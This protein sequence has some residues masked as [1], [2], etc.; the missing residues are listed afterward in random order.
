MSD[1]KQDYVLATRFRLTVPELAAARAFRTFARER[2]GIDMHVGQLAFAGLVL[3]RDIRHV[4]SAAF[5]TLLLASGNRAGKTALLAV[6]II[7]CCIDKTNRQKPLTEKDALRWMAA[8]YHWYHFGIAQEVADLVF[9]DIVRLLSGTHEGQQGKG[10][11]IAA[12]GPVAQWDTKEYGDY[13][14]V[15]FASGWGGAQVHFRT[16]GEKALGSLGKDMHGVS[17]DEAG[18]ERNLP[19]LIK[20]VFNL[21]RLGTG[22][23]LVMVSTPSEDLGSDFADNWDLGDPTNPRRLPSWRSLRMSSRDNIGYGLDQTMFDRLIADMDQRT[24]AQNIEG[25]FLQ[26]RAAYF[27]G[28]NIED[29]FF[30]GGVEKALSVQNGIYLQ[31]VDPAKSADSAWSITLKI[32]ANPDEPDRPFLVGVNAEQRRGQKSTETLVRLVA[33][34]YNLYGRHGSRCYTAIDA[35]GFGGKMFREAL[36]GIVPDV[37]NVEFGGTI[38]RKRMLLGDLRTLID[39]GRLLLPRAG[40]WL[41]VRKQLLGYRL[42]DR[43]IEQDAVMALCCAVFLLRRTPMGGGTSQPFDMSRAV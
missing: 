40:V 9:S 15:R 7:Y 42:E 36:D 4:Y 39:E 33:D 25:M 11:P 38:Q 27:N 24:I 10:C 14:W 5:L 13:R 41:Q 2:L 3:V 29:V 22:G 43:K 28:A 23:Q 8:E 16:T 30:T 32:V 21:R 12:A 26:A 34:A 19:F 35:T 17:F 1:R 6:L 20:E 18:I 31:G 37:T